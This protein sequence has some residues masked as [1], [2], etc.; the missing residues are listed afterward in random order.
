M[1]GLLIDT[2][3]AA[4]RHAAAATAGSELNPILLSE[5]DNCS[6]GRAPQCRTAA[7]SKASLLEKQLNNMLAA[8][9]KDETAITCM[10]KHPYEWRTL[11]EGA[12]VLLAWAEA[13]CLIPALNLA[14]KL[15]HSFLGSRNLAPVDIPRTE[16]QHEH[17][18][19]PAV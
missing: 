17:A 10:C 11:C 8:Q 7:V 2:A 6:V 9:T 13:V 15:L 18:V 1:G 3:L 12:L 5:V 14:W 16:E 4:V 19:I